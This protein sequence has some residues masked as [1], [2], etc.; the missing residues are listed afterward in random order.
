VS[1]VV[2]DVH[3]HLW[4]ETFVEG[5]RRRT[6][7]PYLRGWSLVTAG[8]P[9]YPVNSADHDIAGR[10]QLLE[11]DGVDL[12]VLSLS[13]PLGIEYLDPDD[14]HP[15]LDSWH[16]GVREQ[17]GSFAGW[18]SVTIED[19][20]LP[21]LRRL[22]LDSRFVGLQLPACA[23]GDPRS[24]ERRADVL[25]LCE[26]VGKP[27]LIHPGPVAAGSQ[28]PQWWAPAVSYV[29]QLNAAWWSWQAVGR[30]SF[31]NLRICFAAGAGLAPIHHE[32][33]RARG[34][35]T[36][37]VDAGVF[38]EVS[39]YGPR[40]ID[41]LARAVGI[42]VLVLGS[43]R[44]YASPPQHTLGRAAD[45]ALTVRNPKRLIEGDLP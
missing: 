37:A 32:R 3:Q 34:G 12:A 7:P 38:I 28:L 40:A 43:D 11:K 23:V 2:I 39:S 15:L 45:R 19:Y 8:E 13:S 41:A 17:Q 31:P 20:D 30:S 4:P 22:L 9:P 25:A 26:E 1:D 21:D 27:V 18:A 10:Q 24:I 42:D 35:P 5:L 36:R 44:P 29:S 16:D 33:V 14:A 6:R